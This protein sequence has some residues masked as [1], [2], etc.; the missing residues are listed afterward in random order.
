MEKTPVRIADN[1]RYVL[2]LYIAGT[3]TRSTCAITNIKKICERD[4]NDRYDL[5]VIDI[6]QHPEAAR[7][8]QIVAVPTLV[9]ELPLPLQRFI[10]DLS[11]PDKVILGMKITAADPGRD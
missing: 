1:G 7:E 8:A 6:F 9:K 2:R 10:G 4:L 5:K 3:G 11:D